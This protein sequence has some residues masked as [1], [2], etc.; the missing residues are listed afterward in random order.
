M[1]I[2]T[3]DG[4]DD[5]V[6]RRYKYEKKKVAK[7]IE[8]RKAWTKFLVQASKEQDD[9]N[10]DILLVILSNFQLSIQGLGLPQKV[11]KAISQKTT[12]PN[13]G[14]SKE[15]EL[16]PNHATTI[17][18]KDVS[19]QVREKCLGDMAHYFNLYTFLF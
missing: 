5:K 13:F 2:M 10:D 12:W 1:N 8:E 6:V 15:D 11:A 19:M 3:K 4:I 17:V 14:A 7:T 18:S 9:G 16:S